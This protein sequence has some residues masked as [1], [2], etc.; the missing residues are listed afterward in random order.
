MPLLQIGEAS[1]HLRAHLVEAHSFACLSL[2]VSSLVMVQPSGCFR[3][4]AP[5]PR[6]GLRSTIPA[7]ASLL[8]ARA[9][10]VYQIGDE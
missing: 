10:G 6:H 9:Y 7:D 5:A 3:R 2:P 4:E 1:F 8:R